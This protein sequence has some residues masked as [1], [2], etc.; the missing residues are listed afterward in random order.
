MRLSE[1]QAIILLDIA[2]WSLKFINSDHGY[3]QEYLIK[4]VNE[5]FN[6]QSDKLIELDN[7]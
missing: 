5:I 2:R 3:D 7:K 1:K 4:L 6:Q